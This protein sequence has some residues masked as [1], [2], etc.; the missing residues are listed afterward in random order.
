MFLAG[1]R[2]RLQRL[3]RRR[4]GIWLKRGR[5]G[6]EKGRDGNSSRWHEEKKKKTT[7]RKGGSP[8]IYL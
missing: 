7:M 5:G 6:E 4:M 8:V 3:I 1:A 2:M